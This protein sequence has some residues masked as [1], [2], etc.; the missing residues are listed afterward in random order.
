MEGN[1]VIE[2]LKKIEIEIEYIKGNMPTKEMFLD[3][4]ERNLLE[5]SY[6]NEQR[7]NLVAG[8]KVREILKI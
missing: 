8:K 6:E 4:E 1:E 2:R 7:G 3:S 5:E